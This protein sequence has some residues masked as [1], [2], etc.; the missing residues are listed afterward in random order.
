[1]VPW[2]S[3]GL[4]D[5]LLAGSPASPD[6]DFEVT[7]L[8]D[9]SGGELKGLE[10]QYQQPFTFLPGFLNNT[11]FIGNMTFV[12]SEVD[13]GAA[14]KNRLRGQSDFM[15]NATL[16]YEDDK[17]SARAS[18]AYRDDYLIDFPAGNGNTEEGVNATLNFDA[19]I[20]YE[21]VD[22]VRLSLEAINLTDEYSDR[23]VDATNR[24]SNYRHFG[25]E[26]L[27]GARASF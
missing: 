13:Y 23:Y 22:G 26:F 7:R 17:F 9:G 5:S 15:Y 19:S 8:T 6:E 11:G 20:S 27:I 21:V 18:A 25:R 24:V 16:Y 4:P 14:G 1:M 12:D 3:L 10:L 2:R